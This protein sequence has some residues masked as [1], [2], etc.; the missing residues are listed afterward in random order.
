VAR[1]EIEGCRR[2]LSDC[3]TPTQL[4][5]HW[6]ISHSVYLALRKRGILRPF[7]IGPWAFHRMEDITSL[8]IKLESAARLLTDRPKR[9]LPLFG[10]WLLGHG[11]AMSVF[12]ALLD[13]ILDGRVALF[14]DRSQLG[15]SAYYVD[16]AAGVRA[17]EITYGLRSENRLHRNGGSQLRLFDSLC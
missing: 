3:M 11:S 8:S 14:R 12:S 5:Q 7:V 15:L 16:V 10:S 4:K 6:D 9:L 2:W 17:R 13:E 1:T